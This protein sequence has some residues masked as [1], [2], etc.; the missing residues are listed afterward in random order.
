MLAFSAIESSVPFL[1]RFTFDQVFAKQRPEHLRIAVVLA[2]GLAVLRGVIGFV[3]GYLNDWIG[4]RVV[5]DVRNELTAHLQRLDLAF[6][7]R[8]R[9]GQ[10][11]SRVMADVTLMRS[12]VTD[13]V[14]SVFQDT[15][16]LIGLVSVAFYMDWVLALI[17][18]VA[19][20]ARRLSAARVLEAAAAEQPP[21]AGGDGPPDGDAARERAGQ[22][23]RQALRAG[24]PR[25]RAVPRAERADLPSRHAQQPRPLAADDG[26]DRRLRD[27]RHHLVRRR[28]RHGR[29]AHAGQ[30]L[31]LP[32][33]RRF[34]FEPFK[35]LVRTNYTIQQGLA[36][37]ERVF[38]LL[39]TQ[40]DAD[41]SAR[42]E[43][44]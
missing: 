20:P 31:R 26:G 14:A 1:I 17:A 15:T 28:E 42:R 3:A 13:A 4:Q 24:G 27:R 16:S 38:E 19:V 37:A 35:K 33:D 22:S 32:R 23:R 10:I 7:N 34:L 12:S 2:L 36:G 44:C 8:N 9:A 40:P 6:F 25:G 39:D 5:T 41:G 43:R 18:V 29:N 11:V 30:L 21:A